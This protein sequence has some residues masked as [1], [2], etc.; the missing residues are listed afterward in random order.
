MGVVCTGLVDDGGEKLYADDLNMTTT[1]TV[2]NDLERRPLGDDNG[3][4]IQ[5][6]D[7]CQ[8]AKKRWGDV[9]FAKR[10]MLI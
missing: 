4:C 3:Y 9:G 2:T 5:A 1:R 7:V 6:Q 10:V 8:T